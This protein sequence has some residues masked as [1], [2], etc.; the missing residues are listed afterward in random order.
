MGSSSLQCGARHPYI[1]AQPIG[2]V[3]VYCDVDGDHASDAWH[4]GATRVLYHYYKQSPSRF[5]PFYSLANERNEQVDTDIKSLRSYV[6]LK[7][8]L[9][10]YPV[11]LCIKIN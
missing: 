9:F 11:S 3:S 2:P 4:S 5:D 6:D 1:E 10:I 8:R 7:H